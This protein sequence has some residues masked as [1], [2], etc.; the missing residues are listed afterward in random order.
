M[1]EVVSGAKFEIRHEPA[2]A[3]EI[4]RNY[5]SVDKAKRVLGYDPKTKLEDGLRTTWQWFLSK[6]RQGLAK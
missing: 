3:G 6:G 2:R 5:A 4:I 1:Q